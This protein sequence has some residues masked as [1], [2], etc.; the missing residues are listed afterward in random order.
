MR[1][2]VA[3]RGGLCFGRR[4]RGVVCVFSIFNASGSVRGCMFASVYA[5]TCTY[6]TDGV[7]GCEPRGRDETPGGP[8][9]SRWTKSLHTY[10][11]I[12]VQSVHVYVYTRRR[13]EILVY[14]VTAFFLN[15]FFLSKRNSKRCKSK[16]PIISNLKYKI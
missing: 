4:N 12:C 16:T 8:K 11:H 5:H 2:I 1:A 15:I 7:L 9:E 13:D 3:W 6:C 10:V 14:Y